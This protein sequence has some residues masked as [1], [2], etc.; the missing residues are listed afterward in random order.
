MTTVYAGALNSATDLGGRQLGY[1]EELLDEP[2]KQFI[3]AVA[4]RPGQRC[5]DL[6]AGSGS[7]TRWLAERTG[8]SGHVVA[9][10]VDDTHLAV[11][12]G[13]AV[14]RQDIH[15]GVPAGGPFDVI[16]SRLLLLH[17]AR[18]REILAQLVDALA[19]GGWLV[20]GEFTRPCVDAIA[21][22]SD[23]AA[24][25]FRRVV[26]TALYEVACPAG[27]DIEWGDEVDG[28]V[29]AAGLSTVETMRLTRTIAG[30]TTGCLLYSN[31]VEQLD[32]PLRAAGV[33]ADELARFHELMRD[34]RF[35]T[36]FFP[37]LCTRARKPDTA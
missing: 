2:T 30:G 27:M 20:I 16:H 7:I 19:P 12:P 15:D 13:V 36:W 5:L 26:E 24:R 32:A 17:L 10:D 6:G 33:A 9:V 22:P 21:A 1:L 37:F 4:A 34:P 31:Y 8:P 35:R 29:S 11:P 28:E 3:G 25:L 14:H 18:R 23:A